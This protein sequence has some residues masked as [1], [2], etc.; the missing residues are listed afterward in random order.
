MSEAQQ[1]FTSSNLK[2]LGDAT[3]DTSQP[4]IPPQ[5]AMPVYE[6]G[7]PNPHNLRR[8][9]VIVLIVIL[10]GALGGVVAFAAIKAAV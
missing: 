2:N 5:P 8:V 1:M 9:F 10:L 7:T 3:Q 6:N 4:A